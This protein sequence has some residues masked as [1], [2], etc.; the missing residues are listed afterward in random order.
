AAAYVDRILRGDKP[1]DLPVQAATKFE[2]VVNLK[3][4]KAIGL[5]VPPGLL[6]AAD[7]VI[8]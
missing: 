7:E 3:T 5:T 8:E 4:A 2:T 6:V 1:A